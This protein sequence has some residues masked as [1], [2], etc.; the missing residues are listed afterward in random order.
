MPLHDQVELHVRYRH[1][2]L[3]QRYQIATLHRVGFSQ[4]EIAREIGC[5]VSTV[6]RELRRNRHGRHYIGSIAHG[7]AKQRRAL[8]SARPQLPAEVDALIDTGLAQRWS[9]EQIRGRSALLGAGRV[10]HTTIYRRIHR[11]GLRHQLR[12]PKRRRGYGRGRPQRFADRKPIHARPPEVAA[13]CRLGD[14]ELDTIR[15]ACG[16]GVIVTMNERATG[17]IRLGWSAS[18]QAEDVAQAIIARLRPLRREVHT[19]TSDRGSEFAEDRAIERA[20]NAAMYFADPRAPWQRARNENLNGLVR[21][22]FPRNMDFSSITFDQLQAAENALNDRP[23]KRLKFL[24]PAE[25]FFNY[26]RVAL[27]G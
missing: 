23:R 18:G 2:T 6:C 14:W 16:S 1:L 25:V 9:P 26:D 27:Q 12:L 7:Q 10:S 4:R 17:L 22:Y 15:P 5:H 24:T 3:E 11:R 21:E 19:L 13:L 20:L 8:A